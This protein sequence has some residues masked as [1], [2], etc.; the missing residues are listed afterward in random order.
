MRSHNK[1]AF[2]GCQWYTAEPTAVHCE[3]EGGQGTRC[4]IEHAVRHPAQCNQ[5]PQASD[6]KRQIA[7]HIQRAGN[8]PQP[9]LVGKR[10]L[11]FARRQH[12][13]EACQR[14]QR[15]HAEQQAHFSA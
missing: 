14:Q 11:V 2:C 1:P 3:K 15:S 7:Q 13:P 9:P 5:A 12:R 10:V 6:G 8:A 4:G